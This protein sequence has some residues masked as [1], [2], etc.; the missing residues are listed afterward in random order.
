M[1]KVPALPLLLLLLPG[2]LGAPPAVFRRRM[3][4]PHGHVEHHHRVT[5]V[6]IAEVHPGDYPHAVLASPGVMCGAAA[7]TKTAAET[8]V[9]DPSNPRRDDR[10]GDDV[11]SLT[12]FFASPENASAWVAAAGPE[13]TLLGRCVVRG[14]PGHTRPVRLRSATVAASGPSADAPDYFALRFVGELASP[15]DV[16]LHANVTAR[17]VGI[18]AEEEE[19]EEEQ[20]EVAARRALSGSSDCDATEIASGKCTESF[21]GTTVRPKGINWSLSSKTLTSGT[22]SIKAEG[23]KIS[24][25]PTVY[26]ELAITLSK[27]TKFSIAAKGTLE[28]KAGFTFSASKSYTSSKTYNLATVNLPIVSFTMGA[29]PFVIAPS[30]PVTAGTFFSANGQATFEANADYR[31]SVSAGVALSGSRLTPKYSLN[32]PSP[33]KSTPEF[34]SSASAQVTARGWIAG[35]LTFNVQGL[36]QLGV[37]ATNTISATGKVD[38]S[39]PSNAQVDGKIDVVIHGSLGAKLFGINVPPSLKAPDKSVYSKEYLLWR[40]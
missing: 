29:F 32:F 18:D 25:T 12:L 28:V 9:V 1:S 10:F 26:F 6:G 14:T 27:I 38:T 31:S 30:V 37:K 4:G 15:I 40:K 11:T 23:L 39:G 19:E 36:A 34:K 24:I 8:A 35:A 16:F 20:G 33:S 21:K 13:P 3:S 5:P 22:V 17:L 7:E 2:V